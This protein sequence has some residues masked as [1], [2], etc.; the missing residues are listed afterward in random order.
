MKSRLPNLFALFL[1]GLIALTSVSMSLARGQM[2]DASGSMVLCTGTGPMTVQVDREGQP[3]GPMP[4]CP[5]CAFS[6]VDA[7]ATVPAF[8]LPQTCQID[9]IFEFDTVPNPGISPVQDRARG[10]PLA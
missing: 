7:L 4:I 8:S 1:A 10:P 2:R 9:V 3:I 6:F 5:D